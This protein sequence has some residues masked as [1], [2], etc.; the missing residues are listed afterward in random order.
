MNAMRIM[1]RAFLG[2]FVG[3]GLFALVTAMFGATHQLFMAGVCTMM[4]LLTWRE[5]KNE[6][7]D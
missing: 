7:E 2:L 1:N 4:G 3:L 5:I 6:E